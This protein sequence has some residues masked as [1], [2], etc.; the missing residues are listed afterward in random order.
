MIFLNTLLVRL[1]N[2]G[3]RGLTLLSKFALVFF[4]AGFLEPQDLGLYGL[5]AAGVGYSLYLLGFDFYIFTT[6]ELIGTNRSSWGAILKAQCAL[7]LVLYGIFMPLLMLVFF[8]GLLPWAVVGWFFLL[9]VLEHLAQE[10]NRLLIAASEQIWAS[11]VLF[12]RSGL[13]AILAVVVMWMA[14]ERQSLETVLQWWAVGSALA[15]LT[16]F[17]KVYGMR[18]GSWDTSVDWGWIRKGL[19][20]VIPFLVATL[21][22]RALFTADRYV[23]EYL[24]GLQAL[25][26]YVLFAGMCS[27]LLAF[28][29]AAVFAFA[30]PK[31]IADWK[32][33]QYDRFLTGMKS[34]AMQ[35]SVVVTLFVFSSVLLL[36][37]LLDWIGKTVYLEYEEVFYWLLA[38]TVLYGVSMIPHYGLYAMGED[39][40]IIR[41]HIGSIFVFCICVFVLAEPLRALAVPV[42]LCVVFAALTIWKGGALLRQR[43]KC[44]AIYS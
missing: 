9:L 39:K 13:W 18:L 20:V 32:A 43:G 42:S 41:S 27:A 24:Q 30:Y 16:G 34:M 10:L 3:L 17:T 28:L 29:D 44:S 8:S 11:I 7:S 6:R 35:T 40:P 5:L 12:L 33:G 21:A 36:G 25:G 15:V 2:A 14:P 37:S 26:A 22:V 19:K 23:F 38:A 31:L 4:L 1:T